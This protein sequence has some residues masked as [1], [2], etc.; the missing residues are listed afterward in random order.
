MV[1]TIVDD[2]AVLLDLNTKYFYSVNWPGAAIVML[3]EG[4]VSRSEVIHAC[5]SWGMPSRAVRDVDGFLHTLQRIMAS[6]F[7]PSLPLAE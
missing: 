3:L 5:A 4:G 6:A 2:G 1:S 7:D